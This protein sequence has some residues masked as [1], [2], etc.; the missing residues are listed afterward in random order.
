MPSKLSVKASI[1]VLLL[2]VAC[3]TTLQVY[4]LVSVCIPFCFP[5]SV[6]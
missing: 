5:G 6:S 3:Y 4:L 1:T 2:I